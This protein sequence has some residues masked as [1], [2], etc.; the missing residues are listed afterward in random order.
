MKTLYEEIREARWR[1]RKNYYS[2]NVL[3]SASEIGCDAL[4]GLHAG[5]RL[6]MMDGAGSLGDIISHGTLDRFRIERQP[7]D[8]QTFL[9]WLKVANEKMEAAE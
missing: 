9:Y 4:K 6:F 5:M 7:L 8:A 2:T 1:F 3:L